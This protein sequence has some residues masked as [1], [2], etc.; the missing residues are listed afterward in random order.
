MSR[1]GDRYTVETILEKRRGARNLVEYLV[2]WK[3]FA[4]EEATWCVRLRSAAARARAL[5]PPAPAL[6]R[7][8]R[9]TR[10]QLIEDGVGELIKAYERERACAPPP[11]PAAT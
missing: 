11:G 8:R 6:S 9:E 1:S 4:R 2:Q 5:K 7:A 10:K 3:G